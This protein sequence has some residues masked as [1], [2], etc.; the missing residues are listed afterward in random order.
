MR[1]VSATARSTPGSTPR[2]RCS[3]RWWSGWS[4]SCARRSGCRTLTDPV[5][6]VGVANRALPRRLPRATPGCSRWSSRS[7]PPTSHFAGVLDR[8]APDARRAGRRADL[9]RLQAEG[10]ADPSLDP[11]TAAAALCA[12]VEGF[13]R[14]WLGRGEPHDEDVAVATL[15]TVTH[16]VAMR[17]RPGRLR[18]TA[19]HPDPHDPTATRH[20]R[21]PMKFTAEHE[22]FRKSRA[23]RSSRTRSTPT[24]TSGRRPGIFPAHELFQKLAEHRGARARVRPRVR[25]PGRRPHLHPRARGG[26]RPDRT[27][28][29]C[30]WR[31]RCRP[32][33]RRPRWRRFGSHELKH[34]VPRAGHARR[35]GGVDRG[36]RARRRLR[37]RRHPHPRGARR[38]RVGHQR[39]QDVDHQRDPGRLALPARPHLR[40]GRLPRAC[41]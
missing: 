36:L 3:A 34:A 39:P 13:A 25:R 1:R 17:P 22:Q 26:A 31:S 15:T 27:A 20:R 40:R 16:A 33:W 37:R 5:A 32:T 24:S 21:R 12:M 30:P 10:A 6:R 14:H 41:R 23:R 7:P 8:A 18:R 2:R 4:S 28:P 38:R 19:P 29:A 35:D 9:A 11:H